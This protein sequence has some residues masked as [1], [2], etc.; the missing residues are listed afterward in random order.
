MRLS[1]LLLVVNLLPGLG[2][3]DLPSP[4]L[5]AGTALVAG[6]PTLAGSAPALPV[7]DLSVALITLMTR[8]DCQPRFPALASTTPPSTSAP[9]PTP[10]PVLP[11]ASGIISL[12]FGIPQPADWLILGV[13]DATVRSA[14]LASGEDLAGKP[15]PESGRH[16]GRG[17]R[18]DWL[19]HDALMGTPGFRVGELRFGTCTLA[20]PLKPA[21]QFTTLVLESALLLVPRS[22]LHHETLALALGSS[23]QLSDIPGM[24]L[25]ITPTLS[26]GVRVQ[27]TMHCLPLILAVDFYTATHQLLAPLSRISNDRSTT[28]LRFP[29]APAT[30]E[31]TCMTQAHQATITMSFDRLALVGQNPAAVIGPKPVAT[32]VLGASVALSAEINK[33]FGPD[34]ARVVPPAASAAAV[35][36]TLHNSNF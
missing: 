29:Q 12:T 21:A 22:E 4:P 6:A 33:V 26:S 30:A 2:A 16:Y 35:P 7:P 9:T 25:V 17:R 5:T 8:S 11:A 31:V 20:A 36:Q 15:L 14:L 27:T 34:T 10:I 18:A 24:Q 19:F 32:I 13:D 3:Q 23:A 28:E 1:R